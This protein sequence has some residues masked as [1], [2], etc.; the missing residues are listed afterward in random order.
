LSQ[1]R[2]PFP[3]PI[4]CLRLARACTGMRSPTHTHIHHP[5]LH[6]H[7][8]TAPTPALFIFSPSLIAQV[9]PQPARSAVVPEESDAMDVRVLLLLRSSSLLILF[10]LQLEEPSAPQ[11]S[12]HPRAS[13]SPSLPAATISPAPGG[14]VAPSELSLEAEV[15]LRA[16]ATFTLARKC[17]L[18]V[19]FVRLALCCLLLLVAL[20][21][22]ALFLVQPSLSFAATVR[23]LLRTCSTKSWKICANR[24]RWSALSGD[25][26]SIWITSASRSP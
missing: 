19:L 8:H 10:P 18:L 3:P 13:Q 5:H 6:P 1:V 7:T 9:A 22:I 12:A 26:S 14:G 23:A 20:V 2:H 24:S 15:R 21:L 11:P 4:A 16:F 17:V 25:F